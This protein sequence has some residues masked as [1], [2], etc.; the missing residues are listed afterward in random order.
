MSAT[1]PT[2]VPRLLLTPEEAAQSLG[3]S[4]SLVYE[5]MASGRLGS[6]SIGR[7][8]RVPRRVLDDFVESLLVERSIDETLS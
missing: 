6:V 2:E 5:L 3:V 7:C 4:R 1:S 8:R